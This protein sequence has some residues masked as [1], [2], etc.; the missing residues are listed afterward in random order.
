G[1]NIEQQ[2]LSEGKHFFM[3]TIRMNQDAL[4]KLIAETGYNVGYAAKKHLSTF[5]MVE[6]L[7]GWIGL[8]SLAVGIYALFMPALEEKHVAAAFIVIGVAS[9]F[10]NFY[11]ADRDKYHQVGS[12]LTGKFHELRD[13]YQRVKSQQAGTDMAPFLTEHRRIQNEALRIGIPKQLFL[14]D[15]YAHYKF[16]WQAQIGWIDEQQQFRLVR[17]KLPLGLT[18]LVIASAVASA[19]W[20]AYHSNAVV[21]FFSC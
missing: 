7:P 9:M 6:K 2:P 14:S 16:F 20:L 15:W 19:A 18:V 3:A 8:I 13:L 4:L 1:L 11:A 10:L 21:R 17:D 12:Q 5:D